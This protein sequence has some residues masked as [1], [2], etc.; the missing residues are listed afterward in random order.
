[1]LKHH[2]ALISK[3]L[4]MTVRQLLRQGK[5]CEP[6]LKKLGRTLFGNGQNDR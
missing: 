1:M 5:V 3:P 6:L 4:R 2:T